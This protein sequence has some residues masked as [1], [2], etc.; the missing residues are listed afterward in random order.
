MRYAGSTRGRIQ[1]SLLQGINYPNPFF[2]VAHTYLP[3]TMKQLFRWCRYYFLT[4][5]LINATV[6]KLAQYPVTDIM[7]EADSDAQKEQWEQYLQGH[8]HYRSFQAEV[9]L[10]Y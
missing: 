10:D 4:N 8:L 9:G 2:D 1:G 5:P 7:V 3:P 6:F